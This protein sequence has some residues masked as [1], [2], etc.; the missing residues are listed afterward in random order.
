MSHRQIADSGARP[1]QFD[2][3]DVGPRRAEHG[4]HALDGGLRVRVHRIVAELHRQRDAPAGEPVGGVR[5][6]DRYGSFT[7][8]G[9][10]VA[11]MDAE[12]FRPDE[13]VKR[14]A[15]RAVELGVEGHFTDATLSVHLYTN[16]TKPWWR[17]NPP[18]KGS[19]IARMCEKHG[20]DPTAALED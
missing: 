4:R 20:I 12:I 18:L 14:L 11:G 1:W 13:E 17:K 15:R 6:I 7:G 10:V 8:Y 9:A 19:Y 2:L 16:G 5:V 3:H